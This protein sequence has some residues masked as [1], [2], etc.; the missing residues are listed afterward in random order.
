MILRILDL[1]WAFFIPL[2]VADFKEFQSKADEFGLMS[3]HF[4]F[5]DLCPCRLRIFLC[6]GG[7][8][9]T[10]TMNQIQS[11]SMCQV[12]WKVNKAL[13]YRAY[14]IGTATPFYSCM[15]V[16]VRLSSEG[17][18]VVPGPHRLFRGSSPFTHCATSEGWAPPWP[19][20]IWFGKLKEK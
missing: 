15:I 9:P 1:K 4:W 20:D 14:S 2:R 16:R 5:S 11:K 6:K 13:T 3:P 8:K 17:W 18:T 7:I 10:L 19:V 12:Q